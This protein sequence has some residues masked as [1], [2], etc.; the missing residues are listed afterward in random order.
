MAAARGTSANNR[1]PREKYLPLFHLF[2]QRIAAA[3]HAQPIYVCTWFLT[4]FAL[5]SLHGLKEAQTRFH[6]KLKLASS[7]STD[8]VHHVESKFL[9]KQ[10][11]AVRARR[12]GP[13]L[14]GP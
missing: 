11:N 3:D 14:H 10:G 5:D 13:V 7:D 2:K 4:A 12:A 8:S 9:A 6:N 1:F